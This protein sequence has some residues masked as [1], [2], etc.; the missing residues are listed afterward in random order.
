VKVEDNILTISAEKEHDKKEETEN[1]ARR[2]FSYQ[3]FSRAF[4]LPEEVNTSE[5]EGKYEDGVLKLT[6]PKKEGNKKSAAKEI[7]LS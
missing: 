1:Y 6:I 3:S 2:E 7:K 4:W 5:I